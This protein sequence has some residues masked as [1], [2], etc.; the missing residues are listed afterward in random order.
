[1]KKRVFVVIPA[2]NEEKHIGQIIR[3][4]KKYVDDVLVIDDGSKDKT[5]EEAIKNKAIV[6]RHLVN[7]GKGSAVKTGCDYAVNNGADAIIIIDADS[8]HDPIEIKNFIKNIGRYDVV[9]GYRKL[10]KKMPFIFKI[11]NLLINKTIKFLYGLDVNDS[12]CGYRAFTSKSYE[13]LR[14]KSTDYCLESEM[15]AKIGKHGLSYK[16]IPIDTI[17][18]DRYKGTTILDGVKIVFN[19]FWWKLNNI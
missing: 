5:K 4:A 2:F 17:Y 12:Q 1:M 6:L 11:G 3:K 16:E 14:W 18:S 13:K 7:L 9:L 8:Q 19:L 15:V 10:N